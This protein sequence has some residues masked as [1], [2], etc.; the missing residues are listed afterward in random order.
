LMALV[1]LTFSSA[2]SCRESSLRFT[3]PFSSA[4]SR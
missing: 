2:W 4:S 1:S 3:I